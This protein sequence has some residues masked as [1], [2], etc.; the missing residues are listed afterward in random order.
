MLDPG[1]E[2]IVM[3]PCLPS[4]YE[5]PRALGCEITRWPL[6]VTTW[7]WRLDVNFLASHISSKTKLLVMNIPNNPTGYIPVRTEMERILNM[8]DKNG[9]MG[10]L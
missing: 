3:Q 7:G 4:L 10:L 2:V 5:I 6:E 9:H 1:D 8:A